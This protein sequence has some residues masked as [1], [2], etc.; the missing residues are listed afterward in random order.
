VSKRYRP[1]YSEE[2]LAE[3]R[4]RDTRVY[5]VLALLA[6]LAALALRFT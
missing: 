3:A 6:I 4:S 5:G 2:S 1:V